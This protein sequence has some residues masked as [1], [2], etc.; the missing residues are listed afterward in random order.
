[1]SE[2]KDLIEV[3][4]L[5][6]FELLTDEQKEKLKAFK[7]DRLPKCDGSCKHNIF[8]RLDTTKL[9]GAIYFIKEPDEMDCYNMRKFGSSNKEPLPK[10]VVEIT[11]YQNV[12]GCEKYILEDYNRN[13]DKV[14]LMNILLD[15][16]QKKFG[17]N[18]Y[19]NMTSGDLAKSSLKLSDLSTDAMIQD[20]MV[21]LD[22]MKNTLDS[23]RLDSQYIIKA[24][25]NGMELARTN[26]LIE[27]IA[28]TSGMSTKDDYINIWSE[29]ED[30]NIFSTCK[31]RI[32]N[33]SVLNIN[34]HV[35][36]KNNFDN[37][38]DFHVSDFDNKWNSKDYST[39]D[40]EDNKEENDP[41]EDLFDL[42]GYTEITKKKLTKLLQVIYKGKVVYY[43]LL[44]SRDI[45]DEEQG[46]VTHDPGNLIK[47]ELIDEYTDNRE[48]NTLIRMYTLQYK[49]K[50]KK[51]TING[52][53]EPK[54]IKYKT[55]NKCN[56]V[57]CVCV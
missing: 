51:D 42:K 14:L 11:I 16:M 48:L 45:I 15:I 56:E 52:E 32:L 9:I 29:N 23:S 1:M 19:I 10:W 39:I 4:E 35:K 22:L 43:I 21:D 2:N 27:N 6:H 7:F 37:V 8:D 46:I 3:E 44:S 24:E 12:K 50:H 54:K 30:L 38:F 57:F 26:W 31:F 18:K 41:I 40:S 17:Y 36:I 55:C 5:E 28:I 20:L 33:S 34:E 25:E 53:D 13:T 47:A 49:E